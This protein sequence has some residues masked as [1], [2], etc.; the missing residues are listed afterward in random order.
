MIRPVRDIIVIKPEPAETVTASGI[1]IPEAAQRPSKRGTIMAI[2]PEC[3]L[4]DVVIYETGAAHKI[5]Y[6][7]ENF[8]ILRPIN[9]WALIEQQ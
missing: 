2:G 1:H 5:S 4:S 9:I 8:V 7:E 3:Q 6:Q